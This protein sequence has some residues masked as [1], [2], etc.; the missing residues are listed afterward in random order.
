[1]FKQIMFLFLSCVSIVV[2]IKRAVIGGDDKEY[3][4]SPVYGPF[5]GTEKQTITVTYN[6]VSSTSISVIGGIKVYKVSEPTKHF[7]SVYETTGYRTIK[8]GKY[9]F[10][11]TLDFSKFLFDE[12]II[13]KFFVQKRTILKE[14]VSRSC[15]LKKPSPN[16]VK[17][18]DKNNFESKLDNYTICFENNE[19]KNEFVSALNLQK[20]NYFL[21]NSY[22]VIDFNIYVTYRFIKNPKLKSAYLEFDDTE[23]LFPNLNKVNNLRIIPLERLFYLGDYFYIVPSSSLYYN[24]STLD[25]SFQNKSGFKKV[26]QKLYFPPNKRKVISSYSFSLVLE[27]FGNC[28]TT[29]KYD[30]NF[31]FGKNYLGDCSSSDY[32]VVGGIKND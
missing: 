31:T 30:F 20:G 27:E 26:G 25:M 29:Y 18:D 5:D 2:P 10:S 15:R 28:M 32:C 14:I 4:S 13:V 8:K 23:N 7:Y 21:I 12:E 17:L 1:M 6:Y 11:L 22:G 3:V 16:V 24:P 9:N 19:K